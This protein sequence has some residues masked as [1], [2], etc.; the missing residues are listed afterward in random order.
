MLVEGATSRDIYLP[1]GFWRDENVKSDV[2]LKGPTWLKNYKAGL[3]ILPYF[4]RISADKI[5][6]APA[7]I[8][9][10]NYSQI[11]AFTII[12]IIIPLSVV[13]YI[14]RKLRRRCLK[15]KRYLRV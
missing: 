5:I 2:V 1:A 11:Q 4:R 8:R 7:V 12:S 6:T 13:V 15:S 9:P 3:D 10:S 14:G